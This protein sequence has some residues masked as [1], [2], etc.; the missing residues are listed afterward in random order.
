M[1]I[2]E[3][4]ISSDT[5]PVLNDN[6]Q[7]FNNFSAPGADRLKISAT[8]FKKD[9]TDYDDRNFVQLAQVQQGILRDI[10]DSLKYNKLNEVLARRTFDESGH[11]YVKEFV[12]SVRESLNDGE[13]NRGIYN[14]NQVTVNG[15][16]PS[17]DLAIYKISP[18]KAYVRGFEVE[19]RGP[20]FLE[21]PKPRST[22]LVEDEA[23]NFAFGP[24]LE[25]NN[26]Y[27]S[28]TIGFNTSNTVSLRSRRVGSTQTSAAGKEI[29]IGR[30]YD[31]SLES[32][33]Y[34]T[35]NSN[36]NQ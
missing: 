7:G 16:T 25:L 30:I 6:A 17:D 27:G 31:C 12:T 15:N 9:L 26:V 3:E 21:C 14:A 8:L 33:A 32:G 20:S 1:N 11:Y 22:R 23:V 29:G 13:G 34:N 28:A 5:D 35:S 2:N 24:T 18:G 10:Q 36:I 19:L 4:I